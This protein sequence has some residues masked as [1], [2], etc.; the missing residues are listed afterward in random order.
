MLGPF[1]QQARTHADA[2]P[3]SAH[4]ALC[5]YGIPLYVCTAFGY[6]YVRHSAICLYGIR[7]YV[8]TA[9][10]YMSA[11]HSAICLYGIRLYVCMAFGRL[12]RAL[13]GENRNS[14]S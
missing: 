13:R 14:Y 12:G 10:G 7:L 3:F 6:M 5:L 2:W 1:R 11:R 8:C 9:F 4:S